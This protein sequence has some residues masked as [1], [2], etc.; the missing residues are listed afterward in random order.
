MPKTF[1]AFPERDDIDVWAALHPAREVG[2]DFYDFFFLDQ[3]RLAFAIAD[4][5]GKGVPAAVFMAATRS[6]LRSFLRESG[7]PGTALSLVNNELAVDN[8]N[9]MF[10]TI[11]CAVLDTATGLCTFAN[12]GHNL[13][14]LLRAGT[15]TAS[16]VDS[17]RGVIVGLEP[18][19]EFPEVEVQLSCGDGLFLF[20]DGVTE[21]MDQWGELFGAVRLVKV[22]EADTGAESRTVT[23]RVLG[24][25]TN[26]AGN[27]EQSDD[28]TMLAI[29]YR[30]A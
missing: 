24:A 14:F 23:E 10:V 1:P 21:A 18:D 19:M 16:E 8:D 9:C 11:F 26:F 27:T 30:R 6:Y 17:L 2:G 28:I 12:A 20:T 7:S 25:V 15:G 13:P 5:S 22:L 4:V 29:R 3:S